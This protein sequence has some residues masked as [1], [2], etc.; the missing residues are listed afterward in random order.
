[1]SSWTAVEHALHADERDDMLALWRARRTFAATLAHALSALP[2]VHRP[3]WTNGSGADGRWCVWLVGCR[4][5]VE[6]ELARRG[7]LGE[8]LAALHGPSPGWQFELIGPLMNE[9]ELTRPSTPPLL[10]RAHRGTAHECE[11]RCSTPD[12]VACFHPGVGTLYQPFACS[13]LPTLARLLQQCVPLLLTA[14]HAGESNGEEQLMRLLGAQPLTPSVD[15]PLRHALLVN[16]LEDEAFDAGQ[17]EAKRA[18]GAAEQVRKC[19]GADAERARLFTSVRWADERREYHDFHNNPSHIRLLETCNSCYRWWIGGGHPAEGGEEGVARA[20]AF[21]RESAVLFASTELDNWVAAISELAKGGPLTSSDAFDR[22]CVD[23]E[24]LA[25]AV[26]SRRVAERAAASDAH[27]ICRFAAFVAQ[28]AAA[29]HDQRAS[30]ADALACALGD[31]PDRSWTGVRPF[32]RAFPSSPTWNGPASRWTWSGQS[33]RSRSSR[34]ARCVGRC[35]R[36]LIQ[37][38]SG[39]TSNVKRKHTIQRTQHTDCLDCCAARCIH[40]ALR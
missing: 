24:M 16:M 12:L 4:E 13:W 20:R 10:V 27:L 15:C 9:W 25:E 28:Q 31:E 33:A 2:R 21:L 36:V 34:R 32:E 1:M 3:S 37:L 5:E 17:L 18:A 19:A 14:Y 26:T 22:C 6:G 40:A 39:R 30:D 23:A 38:Y 7:L 11:A 8:V 35:R 29:M